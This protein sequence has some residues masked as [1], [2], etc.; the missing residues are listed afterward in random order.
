MKCKNNNNNNNN[1]D[2]SN[3]NN[4]N[5]NNNDKTNYSNLCTINFAKEEKKYSVKAL[6]TSHFIS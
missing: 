5:N 3:N 2:N 6:F 4:N 1:N